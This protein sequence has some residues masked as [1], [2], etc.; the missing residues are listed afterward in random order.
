MF[1]AQAV[2]AVKAVRKDSLTFGAIFAAGFLVLLCVALVAQ[3]L[4]LQW[5][6]WL[7]GA[8][9]EKSLFAGV[10]SAVYTFMPHLS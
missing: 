7:P 6:S 5:R 8:E 4:T 10:K 9:N 3:L 2:G 1:R